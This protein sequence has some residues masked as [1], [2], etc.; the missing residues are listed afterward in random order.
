MPD[1]RRCRAVTVFSIVA[2]IIVGALLRF[3]FHDWDSGRN[4]HPDELF[5]SRVV[6]GIELPDKASDYFRADAS[7]L[8]PRNRGFEFY[9]YG[10]LPINLARATAEGLAGLCGTSTR[11]GSRADSREH[12]LL[13]PLC[14]QGGAPIDWTSVDSITRIGRFLSSMFSVAS[15]LL[16]GLIAGRLFDARVGRLA[17]WLSAACVLPI[18][19]AHFFTVDTFATFF[20]LL[21]FY[22]LIRARR[23]GAAGW[24]GGA[25]LAAAAAVACRLNLLVF[26]VPLAIGTLA[27]AAARRR[28][29]GVPWLYLPLAAAGFY[30]SLRALLPSAFD[31]WI[32]PDARWLQ[33][34]SAMWDLVNDRIPFPPAVQWTDRTPWL[35]AWN[36]MVWWG[37]GLPLGLVA[38][39][40]WAAWGWRALAA[41]R[42]RGRRRL[43]SRLV[44]SRAAADGALAW[45]WVALFFAWHGGQWV[46]SMRYFLPLYFFLVAFAAWLLVR[47]WDGRV[48]PLVPEGPRRA[49]AALVVGSTMAWAAAF[50]A[51]YLQPHP[52][53]AAAQWML[54]HVDGPAKVAYEHWDAPLPFGA[55][56]HRAGY[57]L[58]KM[59]PYAED[60]PRKRERLL[61]WLEEA[62]YVVLSSNRLSAS[63]PRQPLRYPLT[64]RY[65]E[66]LLSGRLGFEPLAAFV[67][68]PRLGPLVFPDQEYGFPLSIDDSKVHGIPDRSIRVPMPPAE[69]AFSVYDHPR[70]VIFAKRPDYSGAQVARQFADLDLDAAYH[71]FRPS[72]ASAAPN[73]YL[74]TTSQWRERESAGGREGVVV[75]PGDGQ[76]ASVLAWLTAGLAFGWLG[77]PIMYRLF[78]GLADRGAGLARP[79]SILAIAT[80]TWVLAA[81][82]I[83]PHSTA[84]VAAATAAWVLLALVLWWRSRAPLTAFIIKHRSACLTS[85]LVF[86]LVFC[87]A[88][89]VRSANPDL[90]HPVYGG[91]KPMDFAY[92]NAVLRSHYFPPHD[93]WFALGT[94]NYYYFGM[95]MV[96]VIGKLAATPAAVAYNLAVAFWLALIAQAAFSVAYSLCARM[97]E[98]DSPSRGGEGRHIVSGLLGV[99]FVAGIGPLTQLSVLAGDSCSM[100]GNDPCLFWNATRAIPAPGEP[101]PITEFPFFTFLYGDLHAHYLSLPLVLLIMG[102]SMSWLKA[103]PFG[104]PGPAGWRAGW[105]LAGVATVGVSIAAVRMTNMWDYP[106]ALAV[107]IALILLAAR[108]GYAVSDAKGSLA[109]L[110][111]P[112]AVLLLP[113]LAL[114]FLFDRSFATGY[115]G[116]EPWRGTRTPVGVYLL[117]Y[118]VFLLPFLL[119]V[120]EHLRRGGAAAV[121]V[122][123]GERTPVFYFLAGL[124]GFLLVSVALKTVPVLLVVAPALAAL[125]LLWRRSELDD[126][127]FCFAALGLVISAGVELVR[128]EGDIGRM[129]TV[130]KFSYQAWVLLGVSAAVVAP[131]VWASAAGG[132]GHAARLS[133]AALIGAGL[134][135]PLLAVPA[136][137]AQRFDSVEGRGLNGMAYMRQARFVENNQALELKHDHD[138]I[139]WMMSNIDGLPVVAEAVSANEYRWG[140][141]V[142]IYTGLPTI[143]GWPHHQRQQKSLLPR[144]VIDQRRRDVDRLYGSGDPDAVGTVLRRYHVSYVFV[145]GLERAYYPPRSLRVF[146]RLREEGQL[147]A[148][149]RDGNTVLYRVVSRAPLASSLLQHVPDG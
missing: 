84:T 27:A 62:D 98:G 111:A 139:A 114:S 38:W 42:R 61:E 57:R 32:T 64:T 36:N 6:A 67:S 22:C 26:L 34:A 135:Y 52:R 28:G 99:L 94:M 8:N 9:V 86:L 130:F 127:V 53:V 79:L 100:L 60:T 20:V 21:A 95:V 83:A 14:L 65:Y 16:A 117:L 112:V 29:G 89:V 115:G 134:L 104:V 7:T 121:A 35:F 107:A 132:F 3:T 149:Y 116:V 113:C 81:T 13:S 140:G 17:L 40:G 109:G 72:A 75:L 18:Q 56:G 123:S 63:I 23:E 87:A 39:A 131:R 71:G 2:A 118:G 45:I 128:I 68:H 110:A 5:L 55:A 11:D 58:L 15:V 90:W 141:R 59:D 30:L 143:L 47:L 88:L 77:F 24:M 105:P 144:G 31:G 119:L 101:P 93:P 76:S 19:A 51:V 148:V 138:A 78:P 25:L 91:E 146:E 97:T 74:F 48:R 136:K 43:W 1:A 82:G 49:V 145:G 44:H 125:A 54:S 106:T 70:V 92:L 12:G 122:F 50:T 142:S 108:P 4:L 147:R 96:A 69:E 10:D 73:G 133:M 129:N 85:E 46:A 66:L 120:V 103:P 124:S 80:A 102:G 33:N 126:A 137:I 41:Q 37:M